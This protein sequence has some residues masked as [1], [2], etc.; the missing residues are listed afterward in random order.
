MTEIESP[1]KDQ[2]L[3]NPYCRCRCSF[4]GPW[5]P[6]EIDTEQTAHIAGGCGCACPSG[7]AFFTYTIAQM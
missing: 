6:L 4:E 7:E 5:F 3:H 2:V 1:G